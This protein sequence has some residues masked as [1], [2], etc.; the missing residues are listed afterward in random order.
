ML[1]QFLPFTSV[2]VSFI[3]SFF[4]PKSGIQESPPRQWLSSCSQFLLLILLLF[5]LPHIPQPGAEDTIHSLASKHY[6]CAKSSALT[7]LLL[8]VTLPEQDKF[9][10]F[11]SPYYLQTVTLLYSRSYVQT[12]FFYLD[13]STFSMACQKIMSMRQRQYS[14]LAHITQISPGNYISHK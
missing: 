13:D 5:C 3:S 12:V 9:S 1:E 4:Y 6:R 11:F 8:V 7:N 14:Q 2:L 10:N